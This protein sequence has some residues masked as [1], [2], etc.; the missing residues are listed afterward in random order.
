MDCHEAGY[1]GCIASPRPVE[2]SPTPTPAGGN[3]CPPSPRQMLPLCHVPG[4]PQPKRLTQ[5]AVGHR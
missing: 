5:T 4:R 2:L 1:L 3:E